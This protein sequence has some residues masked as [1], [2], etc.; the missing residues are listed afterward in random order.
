MSNMSK[1]LKAAIIGNGGIAQTHNKAYAKLA[2]EGAPVEVVAYCDIRPERL[3]NLENCR[4]YTEIDKILS[5]ESGTADYVDI[6]LPTYLHS[7]VA[8]KAMK[9]GFN[10]ICEKPMALN[11]EQA[12]LMCKTA[13]KTGKTLMIAHCNRFMND[14][15]KIQEYIESGK[16]G[17]VRNADF[18]REGGSMDPMGYQNWFRKAE[19]SGG[20]ML[21]LHIHDVDI[22]QWL[23]GMPEA[24]SAVALNIIPCSGYDSMSVNYIFDNGCYVHAGCDWTIKHDK[25][26][27]RAK[28]V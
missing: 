14:T 15:I 4:T 25:F 3:E 2:A 1:K 20:A 10:V 19:L 8:V 24:V 11:Y 13:E 9:S 12:E 16:F 26:N 18:W 7:E 6:C 17:K 22:I 23:F 21:D 27:T 28:R 5:E